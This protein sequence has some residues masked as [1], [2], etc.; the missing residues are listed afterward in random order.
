[1]PEGLVDVFVDGTSVY[2]RRVHVDHTDEGAMFATSATEHAIT[3]LAV[4]RFQE[5]TP[6]CGAVHLRCSVQPGT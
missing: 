2:P 1:M 5:T 3:D 6:D 4:Q